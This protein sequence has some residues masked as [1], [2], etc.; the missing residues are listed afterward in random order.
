[1][2]IASIAIS[3]SKT[4]T[5]TTTCGSTLAAGATCTITVTFTPTALVAYS[6]SLN[7]TESAGAVHQVPL[8]GTGSNN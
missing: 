1:V 6:G 2:G 8:S 7:V 5:K 3:G 4:F